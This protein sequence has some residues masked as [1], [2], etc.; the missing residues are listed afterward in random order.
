MRIREHE[1]Q[2]SERLICAETQRAY[3]RDIDGSECT[4]LALDD[5]F[6]RLS[7][8]IRV[9]ILVVNAE[10]PN[11]LQALSGILDE[12][13]HALDGTPR[14]SPSTSRRRHPPSHNGAGS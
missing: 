2:C 1:T 11:V 3:I 5:R 6:G 8:D 10:V 12:A 7:E 13:A 4:N 9:L 14:S